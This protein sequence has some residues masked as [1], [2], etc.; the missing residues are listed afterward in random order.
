MD[1]HLNNIESKIQAL[2]ESKDFKHLSHDERALVL[3]QIS[4]EDYILQRKILEES[5]FIYEE[6]DNKKVVVAPLTLPN[7]EKSFWFKSH[8]FYHTGLAVAATII[9]MLFIK[10]P[11]GETIK[12]ETKTEYISKVDTVYQKEYIH[13]TVTEVKEKPVVIEKVVEKVKYIE[14]PQSSIATSPAEQYNTKRLLNPGGSSNFPT[15]GITKVPHSGSFEED[16]TSIL[17]QDLVIS[18]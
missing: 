1:K 4:K 14:I 18:D 10:Y 16:G 5:K 7:E 8:P 6:L 15:I 11:S 13:D 12:T 2:L 3:S 9:L 17:V